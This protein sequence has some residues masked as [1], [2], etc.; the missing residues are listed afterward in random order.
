V[1]FGSHRNLMIP[2]TSGC[3]VNITNNSG[4]ISQVFA[5]LEYASGKT[6]PSVTGGVRNHYH[7]AHDDATNLAPYAVHTCLNYPD[8]PGE[9]ESVVYFYSRVHFADLL[10]R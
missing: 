2:F 7:I 10:R 8:G 5:Q 9:V 4:A 6:P 3:T 1:P